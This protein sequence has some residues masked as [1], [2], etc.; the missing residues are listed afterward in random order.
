M[1]RCGGAAL[2]LYAG[3]SM[4]NRNFPDGAT[5]STL[6]NLRCSLVQKDRLITIQIAH[7]YGTRIG[8]RFPL[9]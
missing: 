4:T 5:V 3:S 1:G 9:S 7:R 8:L 6:L 2:Y